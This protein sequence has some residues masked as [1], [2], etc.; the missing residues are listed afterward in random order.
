MSSAADAFWSGFGEIFRK[1]AAEDEEPEPSRLRHI[2][3]GAGKGALRGAAVGGLISGMREAG[4]RPP[5]AYVL[6]NVVR[7]GYLAMPVSA[8]VGG[9][10]GSEAYDKEREHRAVKAHRDELLGDATARA[11]E[12]WLSRERN[13]PEKFASAPL[14]PVP[15]HP[16]FSAHN[17]WLGATL[18]SAAAGAAIKGLG[19]F[20]DSRAQGKD[21]G[22]SLIEGG[23]GALVGGAVGAAGGGILGKLAPQRFAKPMSEAAQSGLHALTGWKPKGMGHEEAMAHMDIGSWG[24]NR[25]LQESEADIAKFRQVPHHD[26]PLEHARL[27]QEHAAGLDRAGTQ[28]AVAQADIARVK[29]N[30]AI[31]EAEQMGLTSLPGYLKAMR[32]PAHGVGKTLSTGV[33]EQW[34]WTPGLWKV[35]AYGMP[36]LGLAQAAMSDDDGHK[37]ARVAGAAANMAGGL[38]GGSIPALAQNLVLQPALGVLGTEG[39]GIIDRL[40]GGS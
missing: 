13:Q 4:H 38:V 12:A 30:P 29:N 14:P 24:A 15:A 18:G 37:G 32:D 17:H 33:R 20:Q 31:A 3:S 27:M 40:R 2:L 36:A 19:G 5:V 28:R 16:F 35:P 8:I 7:G 11:N 1:A 23:K 34:A 26:D 6:S 22:D 9:L 39:G 10:A 21:L 25:R